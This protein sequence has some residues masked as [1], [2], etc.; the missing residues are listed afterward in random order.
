[1]ANWTLGGTRIFV[2]QLSDSAGQ[3]V[4]KL[5]PLDGGTI[6]HTFGYENHTYKLDFLIAGT[7]DLE[8]IKGYAT[9]GI[10]YSL[11]SPWGTLGDFIVGNVTITPTHSIWQSFNSEE[12]CTAMVFAVSMEL[13]EE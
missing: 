7:T 6:Y 3:I 10:S 9:S 4:A 11:I 13:L 5:Q 2:T 8:T 1:M 12:L